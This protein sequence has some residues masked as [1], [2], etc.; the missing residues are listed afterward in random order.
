[1]KP[2]RKSFDRLVSWM[3]TKSGKRFVKAIK[4]AFSLCENGEVLGLCAI[5]EAIRV[6]AGGRE[7]R[8]YKLQHKRA[9]HTR[10][11]YARSHETKQMLM[12]L[13]RAHMLLVDP[14]FSESEI[15]SFDHYSEDKSKVEAEMIN[16]L[17]DSVGADEA[18]AYQLLSHHICGQ[19][20]L[21]HRLG[22]DTFI[23]RMQEATRSLSHYSKGPIYTSDTDLLVLPP[24]Y[25]DR[26]LQ[27]L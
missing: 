16:W 22:D 25:T 8:F 3:A 23:E 7:V 15:S 10:D 5:E 14:A 27:G 12:S 2:D 24:D 20:R 18:F 17:F 26:L 13:A 1:M 4:E 11:T 19:A 9:F 21:C 6:R